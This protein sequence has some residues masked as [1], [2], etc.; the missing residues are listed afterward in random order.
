MKA[1]IL[2]GGK[3]TRLAPYTTVLPKPLMPIGD[4]PILEVVLRQLAYHNFT[5]ITLAVGYLAE[6]IM[7]YCG[8]GAKYNLKLD[9]SRE[10]TPL[11]T[12]GPIGL[13]SGLN[14]TFLVMNGD[15]LTTINYT[16]MLRH[17]KQHGA[18]AT[19]A[20]YRRDVKIDLGVLETN[21]HNTVT[22]YVEKPTY[23]YT[24]STGVYIFEPAVLRY[25]PQGQ[26]L[27]LP[28]LILHLLGTNEPVSSYLHTGY[29]LD[30]GRHDDYQQAMETFEA[31]RQEFLPDE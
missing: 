18:I 4:V 19:V 3:G 5:D 2:A 10:E 8:N 20:T 22:N 13:V 15:L 23:H 14:E 27:D 21:G 28:E 11:G 25:I 24:V 6:L 31:Q 17:H 26:R 30:I 29:W 12:A 7:A 16:E 1:I 9:Y